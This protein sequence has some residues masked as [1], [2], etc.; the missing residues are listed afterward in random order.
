MG[1][2]QRFVFV[3]GLWVA[4]RGLGIAR[5]GFNEGLMATEGRGHEGWRGM[6]FRAI[7]QWFRVCPKG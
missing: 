6:S 7:G 2:A 3:G 1:L 5:M 4:G